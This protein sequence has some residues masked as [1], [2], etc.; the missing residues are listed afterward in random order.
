MMGRGQRSRRVSMRQHRSGKSRGSHARCHKGILAHE[1]SG[2]RGHYSMLAKKNQSSAACQTRKRAFHIRKPSAG[3]PNVVSE[4]L[5][6][7]E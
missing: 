5:R 7:V 2:V 3:R 4:G 6:F 1:L